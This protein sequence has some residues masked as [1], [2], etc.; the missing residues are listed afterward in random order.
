VVES[1]PLRAAVRLRRGTDGLRV[2]QDLR[3]TRH[4]D[5]LEIATRIDV[6][7]RRMLLRSLTTLDVRTDAVAFETAFG[8]VQR[9]THRNTSWDQA[10]FEVP[11]HRWAEATDGRGG[12]ALLNDGRYGHSAEGSTLGL[13][14][15]RAPIHPDPYADEGEHEVTYAL[16][17]FAGEDR[18]GTI[19]AAHDLNAPLL[20]VWSDGGGQDPLRRSLLAV[21]GPGVRLAALKPAEEGDGA[22]LRVYEAVGCPTRARVTAL[23]PGWSVAGLVDLL[24]APRPHAGRGVIE[25]HGYEVTSL[26]LE[27][28]TDV[29]R[30]AS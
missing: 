22:V 7:G 19:A 29:P 25:L 20:G 3:L 12:V 9:P 5:R 21:E 4:G 30:G 10:R 27:R 2:V 16:R 23:P 28:G 15:V 6:C 26:R 11:G 18:A 14:L 13:T 17:P 24:E 1:G 8:A